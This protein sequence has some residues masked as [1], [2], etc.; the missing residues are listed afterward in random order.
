MRFLAIALVLTALSMPLNESVADVPEFMSYQGLLRDGVGDPVPDGNYTLTFRLYD[1][2]TGGAAL[3][4][5]TQTV[6]VAD[7]VFNAK[8]GKV[9]PLSSLEFDV[10]YW[11]GISV[12]AD[13][14]LAPRVELATVPYA[15]HAAYAD[16]SLE[17]DD[18]WQYDGDNIYHDVGRVGIGLSV[19]DARLDVLAG[20]EI[21]ADF[22][23]GAEAG[24]FTLRARNGGGTA[25][26]F[27]SGSVGTPYPTTPS[28]VYAFGGY[29]YRGGFFV[30]QGDE[31]GLLAQSQGTGP[32][33]RG[34]AFGT[35]HSGYF[36]GGQGVYCDDQIEMA[37]FKMSPG[38]V[39][40][41]VLTADASGVGTWQPGAGG[42]DI[43]AVYAGNG[44]LGGAT[45]G[46]A[47][48][49]VGAG[50][51]IEVTSDAVGLALP[52]SSG[53][54]YDSRFVNELQASSVNSSMITD[55]QV[56]LDDMENVFQF[57][58][59]SWYWSQTTGHF[60]IEHT[61]SNY[62]VMILRNQ[63]ATTDGDCLYLEGGPSIG[64]T[65]YVFYSNTYNGK[66]AQFTKFNDDDRYCVQING[67]SSSSEGLYVSGTIVS[68]APFAR[69]VETSRGR[70]PVFGVE[71]SEPEVVASGRARLTGG[72]ADV[73][74]D[75]MFAESVS[76]DADVRVTVTP[77]GGWSALY[78]ESTG[79]EG[80]S[81]RSASGSTEIDFYWTATGRS[82]VALDG[83]SI[84]LPDPDE[85]RRIEAAKTSRRG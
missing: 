22:S 59:D 83:A 19:M 69:S 27:Y 18:D 23:N 17:G 32:A 80:F 64:H 46:D 29:G 2:E 52:Y 26:G 6:A 63:N 81:V 79:P 84:T 13:P 73:A 34:W 57:G 20:N 71:A 56:R 44:L 41:Y 65:T 54:A 58:S 28:A 60:E 49:G 40:G 38:A 5:E 21:C 39:S 1:V 66:A 55:G 67:D 50:T 11:L 12:G 4:T 85:E 74:F 8:L 37:G 76:G 72:A 48:L 36:T 68:T 24:N 7:G 35:G 30:A 9:V 75:R 42:G 78:V 10:P 15:G 25:G 31:E 33:L 62:P 70:E 51:G 61:G 3:W 77:I 14:E 16:H 82:S 47:H 53:S 45:S 43:T